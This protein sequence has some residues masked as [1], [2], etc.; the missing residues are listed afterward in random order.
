MNATEPVPGSLGAVCWNDG[1][2]VQLAEIVEEKQQQANE[3]DTFCT[4]KHSASRTTVKQACY[5]CP[6]FHSLKAI[7]KNVTKKEL[8]HL[9]LK[10]I[11]TDELRKHGRGGKLKLSATNN[12]AL[13]SFMS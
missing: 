7:S 10:G 4:C 12:S 2:N 1:A 13:I 3:R 8:P 5:Y 9:R 6:V 11:V